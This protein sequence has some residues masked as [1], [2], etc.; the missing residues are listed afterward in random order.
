M[1][2]KKGAYQG[3][4]V[5]ENQAQLLMFMQLNAQ[6]PS[7]RSY[8]AGTPWVGGL[9]KYC[10]DPALKSGAKKAVEKAIEQYKKAV[11]CITWENVDYKSGSRCKQDQ[12]VYITSNNQGC[13]SYVGM[14]SSKS[15][16]LN[17]QSPGCDSVG[18]TMHEL[19]H[20][21]GMGH[22]QSRPD[23]DQ[24]VTINWDNIKNGVENN[25]D[26]AQNG[27]TSR[28][29]DILSLMH[30]GST[31]FGQGKTTISV[32][33]AAYAK[34]TSDPEQYSKY[35][36]GER[37]GLSQA[38]ADQVADLYKSVVSG[39]CVASQLRTAVVCEDRKVNGQPW[40]DQYG[41]GCATYK[42][43]ETEGQ[44]DSCSAYVSGTY[45]CDCGG[46]YQLQSWEQTAPAP[47]AATPPAPAP[48][49]PAPSAP[50]PSAPAPPACVDSTTYT[51]PYFGDGCSG[52]S[53]YQCS[54]FY[55]SQALKSNCPKAC[56]QCT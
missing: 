30:Y 37:I 21:L 40:T 28:P 4:M 43:M 48:S 23:R 5:P 2:E 46:G 7:H 8:G 32:K 6:A 24:Y 33:A 27:D 16:Q 1:E 14:L 3:D 51:D 13:W 18:T 29:Y 15:Q 53:G 17:L 19:G 54:G 25:F 10:Y 26:I 39:G 42:S 38:D 36:P 11:P 52:W 9:L 35:E 31:D 45:C 12:A 44:I 47:P 20:A 49:A 55:F 34:Y 22:E 41:Q 56:N 50:A